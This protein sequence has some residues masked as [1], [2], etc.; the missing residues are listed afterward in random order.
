ME[1]EGF[2]RN[3]LRLN[4]NKQFACTVVRCYYENEKTDLLENR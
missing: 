1:E 2:G 3:I 4:V